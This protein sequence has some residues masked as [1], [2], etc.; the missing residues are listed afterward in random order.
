MRKLRRLK[1]NELKLHQEK[2]RHSQTSENDLAV[3]FERQREELKNFETEKQRMK[4]IENLNIYKT[5]P[6]LS[7]PSE[8]SFGSTEDMED[9]IHQF[10]PVS[11]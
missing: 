4:L 1:E 10:K 7:L 2:R 5:N 6:T 8:E 11:Q 9:Q 3:D